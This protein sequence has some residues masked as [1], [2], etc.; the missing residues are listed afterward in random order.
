MGKTGEPKVGVTLSVM[1]VSKYH[2]DPRPEEFSTEL[3][4]DEKGAVH[5]GSLE[6]V[7]YVY[8]VVKEGKVK[9]DNRKW[10]LLEEQPSFDYQR[11]IVILENES[12]TLPFKGESVSLF[13]E[14]G[15]LFI[16]DCTQNCSLKQDHILIEG[17][18]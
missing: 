4:T 17:L 12:I 5:L 14:K 2:K 16:K 10:T 9:A 8:S 18:S 11:S 6:G 7:R 3:R 13:L 1:L 15:E